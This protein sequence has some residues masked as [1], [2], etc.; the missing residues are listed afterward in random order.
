MTLRSNPFY[1]IF[2]NV[3][4]IIIKILP[5]NCSILILDLTRF[6]L[7]IV[8]YV[9]LGISMIVSYRSNTALEKFKTKMENNLNEQQRRQSVV[10]DRR[11]SVLTENAWDQYPNRGRAWSVVSRPDFP[12]E[13]YDQRQTS[14]VLENQLK[15][16]EQ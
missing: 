8:H 2:L 9:V 11:Q 3:L 5:H 16:M 12:V 4:S 13:Q 15:I 14:S 10:S 1:Y 6:I 7:S